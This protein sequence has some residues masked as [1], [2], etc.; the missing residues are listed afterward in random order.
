MVS[1]CEVMSSGCSETGCVCVCVDWLSIWTCLALA[2]ALSLQD[3]ARFA[4]SEYSAKSR[5]A[6]SR[7]AYLTGTLPSKENN[8]A[9]SFPQE[10]GANSV[11]PSPPPPPATKV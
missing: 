6:E 2:S 4:T 7:R 5:A 11:S 3:S 9:T 1:C 8:K 10:I